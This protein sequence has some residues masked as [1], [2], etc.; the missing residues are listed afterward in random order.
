MANKQSTIKLI[1]L[2]ASH[3]LPADRGGGQTHGIAERIAKTVEVDA[4][5]LQAN[6]LEAMGAV[7]ETLSNLP[8][9]ISANW[10]LDNITIGLSIS[11]EGSVGIATAGVE[12]SIEVSFSPK[13]S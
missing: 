10:K 7:E 1:T 13:A 8:Q 11:A 2:G 3:N 6:I 5:M 9:S 12:A 4:G